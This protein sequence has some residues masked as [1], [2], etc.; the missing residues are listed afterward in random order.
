[1]FIS[2]AALQPELDLLF[3]ERPLT[4]RFAPPSA[5]K[6]GWVG[7][8]RDIERLIKPKKAK[9]CRPWARP[10]DSG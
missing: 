10:E 9:G 5:L 4:R 6:I 7:G 3:V 1:M 2:I 8:Q